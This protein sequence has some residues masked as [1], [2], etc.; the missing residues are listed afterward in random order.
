MKKRFIIK[1]DK[2]L[3]YIFSKYGEIT[4]ITTFWN[5]PISIFTIDDKTKYN[6]TSDCNTCDNKYDTVHTQD[7]CVDYKLT[8]VYGRLKKLKRLLK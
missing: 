8:P 1:D 2:E 4:I 7:K 6:C 5:Y 3:K